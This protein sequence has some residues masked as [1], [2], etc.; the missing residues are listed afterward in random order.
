MYWI[1][2]SF[3][4]GQKVYLSKEIGG[5]DGKWGFR[6]EGSTVV[7]HRDQLSIHCMYV[8]EKNG[9]LWLTF[10]P[11]HDLNLKP[12]TCLKMPFKLTETTFH[13]SFLLLPLSIAPQL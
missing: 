2:D 6:T 3:S 1:S 8:F 13:P 5:N 7:K 12:G 9:V 4:S 11:P 10:K